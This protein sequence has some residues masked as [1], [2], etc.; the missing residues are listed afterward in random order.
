MYSL[1]SD[2]IISDEKYVELIDNI[3]LHV[4]REKEKIEVSNVLI[5]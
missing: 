5:S 2:V 4:Q 3:T 1:F